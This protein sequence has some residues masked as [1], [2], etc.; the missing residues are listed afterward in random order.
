MADL[1]TATSTW[2]TGTLDTA[3]SV[4]NGVDQKRAEH[5]NG[6]A[7]AII[8]LETVLGSASSL[9]GSFTDLASRLA[10]QISA[11]GVIIPPGTITMYGG[12]VAPSG[13]LFCDGSAA[14]RSTH[15]DLYAVV[16]LDFGN[17]LGD[18]LTFS[19]PYFNGRVPV[20]VGTGA[21]GGT[22]GTTGTKP[23][24][25]A[26]LMSWL[27]GAWYG[28]DTHQLATTEMPS[29]THTLNNATSVWRNTG[30][31]S[32]PSGVGVSST[33]TI[34]MNSAGSSQ[35]HNNIQASLCVNFIIKT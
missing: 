15:A 16:G 11:A 17:G 21:G 20:G 2:A 19:L 13:W 28:S 33:A 8:A 35:P 26:T 23:S 30:G 18:G 9:K 14:S 32:N 22:S 12:S 24:G 7:S 25:G 6:P 31:A 34:T 1:M 3:S 10:I 29:H 5:I 4:A 27:R